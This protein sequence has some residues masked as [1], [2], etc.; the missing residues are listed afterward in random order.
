[1]L[2]K[3]LIYIVG[4]KGRTRAFDYCMDIGKIGLSTLQFILG[5]YL[6]DIFAQ[7]INNCYF[8]NLIKKYTKY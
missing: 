3:N 7:Y 5:R 8:V 6:F 1:V 2:I 4:H